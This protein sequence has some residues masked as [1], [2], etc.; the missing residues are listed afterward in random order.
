MRFHKEEEEKYVPFQLAPMIDVI[1]MLLTF[2]I[3][4]GSYAQ[5][6]TELLVT[7]PSFAEVQPKPLDD[8]DI[9]T[10]EIRAPE[11]DVDIFANGQ[12]FDRIGSHE[13]PN[14]RFAM[15]QM[16][17]ANKKIGKKFAASIQPGGDVTHQRVVDV[18]NACHEAGVE[19]VAFGPGN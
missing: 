13:L 3:V 16:V 9:M 7:L 6:E 10:I 15:S 19:N 18:L 11:G 2:F 17:E 5:T 12:A 4:A 14:L 1:F 8:T